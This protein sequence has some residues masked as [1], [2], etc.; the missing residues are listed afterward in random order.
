MEKFYGVSERR[1]SLRQIGKDKWALT[2]GLAEDEGGKFAW[3]KV[4][5]HDPSLEEVKGDVFT[6]INQLTEE[7]IEHGLEWEGVTVWL[8][9]ENQMN[10][11]A[12]YDLAFQGAE[13]ALPVWLKIGERNGAQCFRKFETFEEIKEFYVAIH[14]HVKECLEEGWRKKDEVDGEI[15]QMLI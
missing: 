6:L 8:S 14:F 3:H 5:K 2:Y 4:Y 1:D 15:V 11:K 12:A 9:K 7:R 13:G 10:F